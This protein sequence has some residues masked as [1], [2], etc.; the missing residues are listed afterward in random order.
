M[1]KREMLRAANVDGAASNLGQERL[2]IL[3]DMATMHSGPSEPLPP[4][5]L[6]SEERA[7]VMIAFVLRLEKLESALDKSI[8]DAGSVN[9]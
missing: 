9:E 8:G 7:L 6:T 3:D 5:E 2:R 1:N 4:L